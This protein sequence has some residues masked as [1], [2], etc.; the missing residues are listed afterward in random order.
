MIDKDAI[1]KALL[2]GVVKNKNWNTLIL[3]GITEQYFSAN[4]KSLYQYIKGYV[5]K[6]QYPDLRI[7]GYEFHIDDVSMSEYT[8]ITDLD[9]LCEIGRAHV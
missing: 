5:D 4:N 3:N 7:L 2:L 1:E 9:S 6:E 8:S